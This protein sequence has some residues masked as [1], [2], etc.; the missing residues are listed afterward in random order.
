VT[1][2][3][4]ARACARAATGAGTTLTVLGWQVDGGTVTVE[5]ELE[6]LPV[7]TER[8]DFARPDGAPLDLTAGDPLRVAALAGALD[9]LALA[10]SVSYLKA[11]IPPEVV[12]PP[13]PT[14]ARRMLEALV[15]EGL[16]E[17]AW[18]NDLG[19]LD[20]AF[21]LVGD[22][23]ADLPPEPA[24]VGAAGGRGS[25]A[26]G[27]QVL[28]TIGG[29]KDS[30]LTA[31]TVAARGV[32]ALGLAVNPR[33]P[34]L[35]T[36]A[37]AGLELV[38]VTRTIDPA[39]LALN[40]RGALNGH[41]PITAI[42]T[43][44]AAVAAVAL[45][46]PTV[47]VSNEGSADA[48]T[49][50]ADGWAINHQYSKSR[51]FEALLNDALDAAT[52][53]RVRVVSLLR[54]LPELLVARAAAGV[55]GLAAAAT[56]CNRV[57]SLT[58]PSARWCGACAKCRFVQ[59]MLAPFAPRESLTADL[60]FDAL[61]DP[62]QV[63][64]FADLLDADRKPFECV[65]TVEEVRL[66]LDLLAERPDWK[67]AAAVAAH[68]RAGSATAERLAALEADVDASGLPA[69]FDAWAAD[70]ARGTTGPDA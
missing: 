26:A 33:E 66:A 42:V 10:T 47:L 34:M 9:L 68:G 52:G 56:S 59:L 2:L 19:P 11:A 16:A 45:A 62:A 18:T 63:D 32:A 58:D 3:E 15:T 7:L 14:A 67:D 55:P 44:C 13:V 35:R 22:V 48:P 46:I 20:D 70:L 57:F 60:G 17:F 21:T 28:V 53:R 23:A 61:A 24:E 12:L 30:A 43:A 4:D 41:V 65:G 6:G 8:F 64:G 5:H 51:A 1:R 49:R 29:G 40:A 54:P 69:P 39:L 36:A 38:T 31:A 37:L 25:R 50:T 27:P